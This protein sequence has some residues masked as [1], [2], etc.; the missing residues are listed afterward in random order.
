MLEEFHHKQNAKK[1]GTVHA[2][3]LLT[4]TRRREHPSRSTG[5]YGRDEDGDTVMQSSPP[6]PSSSA[7][8]PE[9]AEVERVPWRSVVLVKEEHLE[10]AKATFEEITS[11]HVYSL[12]AHG[13]GDLQLLTECNRKIAAR[14]ASEDP[15]QATKQYGTIQNPK[16]KRRM[17]GRKALPPTADKANASGIVEGAALTAPRV[18]NTFIAGESQDSKPLSRPSSAKVTSEPRKK[19]TAAKTQSSDIFKSFAKSKTKLK[20]DEPQQS[21]EGPPARE[22]E[23]EP[24]IDFSEEDADDVADDEATEAPNMPTGKSKKEREE[25]LKAMMDQE[26]EEIEDSAQARPNEAA[27]EDEEET[28]IDMLPAKK[29]EEPKEIVTVENG[30]C[31]GRRRVMK[32]K[33]VK[34]EDGYLGKSCLALS[35]RAVL[36]PCQSL[37]KRLS[38]NPSLRMSLHPR[39]LK[40]RPQQAQA[41]RAPKNSGKRVRETSC[42]FSPRSDTCITHV[43]ARTT[44]KKGQTCVE[45]GSTCQ[46]LATPQRCFCQ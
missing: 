24:M 3:Y 30:R 31:R 28:T 40:R 42:H 15:L 10:Q 11:V 13:L 32:K 14:Y 43:H 36:M 2:T 20:K 45:S 9:E 29:T 35:S 41:S 7:A 26:D 46:V 5:M 21:A 33:T 17:L 25:E 22:P 44:A 4:G 27:Q 6:L 37:K 1:S 34:D 38:G 23:D 18:L 12:E 19:S 39:R 8:K 16:V